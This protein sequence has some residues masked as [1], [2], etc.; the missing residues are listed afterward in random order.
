MNLP[1]GASSRAVTMSANDRLGNGSLRSGPTSVMFSPGTLGKVAAGSPAPTGGAAG[2]APGAG[3]AGRSGGPGGGT[4]IGGIASGAGL[5]RLFEP[6]GA[7]PAPLEPPSS[8]GTFPPPGK[9]SGAGTSSTL[10]PG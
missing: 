7:A 10:E 5:N 8:R 4:T 6:K 9:G 1:V 3:R 2:A